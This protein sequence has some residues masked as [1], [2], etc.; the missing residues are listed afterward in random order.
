MEVEWVVEA[1]EV[2]EHGDSTIVAAAP[3]VGVEDERV[4]VEVRVT[5]DWWFDLE[6][7]V[8]E[9]DLE[10]VEEGSECLGSRFEVGSVPVVCDVVVAFLFPSVESENAKEKFRIFDRAPFDIFAHAKANEY[11]LDWP[12]FFGSPR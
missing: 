7:R 11:A 8:D 5:G 12:I 6:G 3:P 1:S 9:F 4:E 2:T 10:V